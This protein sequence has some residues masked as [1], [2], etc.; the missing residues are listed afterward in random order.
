MALYR[1]LFNDLY[2]P[3][4]DPLLDRHEHLERTAL[5][6]IVQGEARR[7]MATDIATCLAQLFGWSPSDYRVFPMNDR[8]HSFFVICPGRALM[9]NMVRRDPYPLDVHGISFRLTAW[10]RYVHMIRDRNPVQAWISIRALPLQDWCQEGIDRV[11]SGFGYVI[12]VL[13]Y[14]FQIGNFEQIVCHIMVRSENRIPHRVRYRRGPNITFVD[15]SLLCFRH[16]VQGFYP[17]PP[18]MY[19]IPRTGTFSVVPPVDSSE[20][21]S[22]SR[23]GGSFSVSGPSPPHP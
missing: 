5:I 10:S 6:S 15:I 16:Q 19:H 22:D 18:E 3:L 1:P 4:G 12:D 2:V 14:G 20:S 11:V 7:E 17:P 13:P 9:L 8:V 21:S 23:A